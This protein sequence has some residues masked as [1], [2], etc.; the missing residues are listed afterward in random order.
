MQY[1]NKF[2]ERHFS[3]KFA[4]KFWYAF[5]VSPRY[6]TRSAIIILTDFIIFAVSE[7]VTEIACARVE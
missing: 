6:N 4:T 2:S 3:S 1:T 5:L 7:Y